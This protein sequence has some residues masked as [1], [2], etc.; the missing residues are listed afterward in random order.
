[1]SKMLE[2]TLKLMQSKREEV[3]AALLAWENIE[4]KIREAAGAG[5]ERAILAP[6]AAAPIRFKNTAAAAAAMERLARERFR[7]RWGEYRPAPGGPVSDQL[8]IEW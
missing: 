7:T 2:R 6:P 8:E 5:L 1:M 3:A 4:A